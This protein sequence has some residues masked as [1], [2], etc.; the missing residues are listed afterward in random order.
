MSPADP[1]APAQVQVVMR[2]EKFLRAQAAALPVVRWAWVSDSRAEG[3]WRQEDAY[4]VAGCRV[5]VRRAARHAPWA[6]GHGPCA[7]L[8]PWGP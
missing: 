8:A 4:L 2:T 5:E 7:D 3:Q 1:A 6:M